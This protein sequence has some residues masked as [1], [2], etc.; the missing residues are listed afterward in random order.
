M[1]RHVSSHKM[2]DG[3]DAEA[4][5]EKIPFFLGQA[6]TFQASGLTSSGAGA[7]VVKIWCSNREDP[8]TESTDDWVGAGEMTLTLSDER[9]S[10]GMTIIAPWRWAMAELVSISGT[11]AE[12]DV[13]VGG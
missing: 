3:A 12:V 4:F 2:L 10:D 9:S 11:G 5:S 13:E 6:R 7:A 1:S 8:S